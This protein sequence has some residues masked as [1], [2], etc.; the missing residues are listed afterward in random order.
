MLVLKILIERLKRKKNWD[1]PNASQQNVIDS[2]YK[3]YKETNELKE[4]F[5]R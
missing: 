3:K 4:K 5:I 1:L 2:I